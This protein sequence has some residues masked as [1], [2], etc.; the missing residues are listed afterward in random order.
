MT[1]QDPSDLFAAPEPPARR[2]DPAPVQ[3]PPTP[4]PSPT[5][6]PTSP[7]VPGGARTEPSPPGPAGPPSEVPP[8]EGSPSE[9]SPSGE[10]AP[11]GAGTPDPPRAR[12]G[13][14]RVAGIL[15]LALLVGLLGGFAG[16]RI[17]G[18]GSDGDPSARLPAATGSAEAAAGFDRPE[19]S[20]ASTAADVL[21]SVVSFEVTGADDSLSSGSGFVLRADGYVLTNDHVVAA[22]TG[23]GEVVVVLADGS[24]HEGEVVGRT[25]DYDLAVVKIDADGLTPLALGDSDDVVVGDEVLAVGAP[26]GLDSTVTAGIVSALHRPVQAGDQA[27]TAFIDAIQTDAA[28]N[29]GNSGG[30]LVNAAGEVIGINSAIA[31]PPGAMQA[32][33]SIGLGFAIPANQVRTTAEQLIESGQAT[34]PVIGVLLDSSYT[35]EGVKVAEEAQQGN[36]PVTDGGPADV[37]GIRAGDIILEIDGRPVAQSDELI[38]A[39]R[40]SQPGDAVTLRVRSGDDERDVRVVL[41]ERPSE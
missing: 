11:T 31:Q 16:E 33:G 5:P 1:H 9:G 3:V 20:L 32:T 15:V 2:P 28:I 12:L 27:T 26:L 18:A 22:G 39:I 36:A 4:A 37:A 29:P 13:G 7:S 24:E 23:G 34:Y 38:V 10:P 25:S 41:Q 35:G 17:S 14:A 6:G 21:P 40:A 8:S 30:P 19:G